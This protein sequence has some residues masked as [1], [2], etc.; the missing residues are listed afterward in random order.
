MTKIAI[1]ASQGGMTCAYSVGATLALAGKHDLRDPEIIIGCSGS[2]GTLAYFVAKQYAE[3][4]NVWENRL[5]TRKFISFARLHR[6]MNIDYMI[7]E[8]FKKQEPLNDAAVRA[9]KTEFLIGVTDAE[10]GQSRYISNRSQVD[11]F[12]AIRA[13]CAVPVIYNKQVSI[14][15]KKY[16]DGA[17]SNQFYT[18]IDKARS[19]GAEKI[20]AIDNADSDRNYSWDLELYLLFRDQ[21][22]GKNVRAG[23]VLEQKHRQRYSQDPNVY[24]IRPSKKI[25]VR[26]LD[27]S[28]RHIKDTISLGYN[29][30]A[31]N[32]KLSQFLSK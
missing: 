10:T 12:E 6:I 2:A 32:R 26:T 29:D 22:F 20:V 13:S 4:R 3:F 17:I 9:S 16:I 23:L 30:V 15:G 18:N 7:D 25:P 27:V 1:V 14:E 31:E 11:V 21:K 8:V 5:T 19:S 28:E 24:I